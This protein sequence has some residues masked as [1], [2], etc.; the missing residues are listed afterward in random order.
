MVEVGSSKAHTAL[1]VSSAIYKWMV[2][3]VCVYTLCMVI[4]HV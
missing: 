2:A 3:C 4:I 1:S